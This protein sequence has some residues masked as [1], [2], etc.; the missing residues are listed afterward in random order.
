MSQ[1]RTRKLHQD[2]SVADFKAYYRMKD[3]LI[4][5]A[6]RLGLSAD[7][8][9]PELTARIER[10]LRGLPVPKDP[11]QSKGPRDSDK[12]LSRSTTVVNYR[13]DEKTRAFFT[14]QIGPH[15]HFTSHV[16]QY[17]LTHENLTYGDLID[18]WVAEYERRKS[19]GYKAPIASHGEYNRHIRDFFADPANKG[20]T[21]RNAVVSWKA[22]KRR[23][24]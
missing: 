5:F 10:R 21:L 24:R 22:A 6:R 7:G 12:P 8:Y 11:K 13:S 3:D 1:K 14:R 20:K 2:M 16:N 18:E 4:K 9:K 15:F 19:P 17:R 23:R